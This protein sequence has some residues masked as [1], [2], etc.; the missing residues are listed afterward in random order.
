[1]S[2]LALHKNQLHFT[3]D[4]IK[5]ICPDIE[6]I[7]GAINGFGLLYTV[8]HFNVLEITKT[9]NFVHFSIQEFLA[10]NYIIY[11]LP[12]KELFLLFKEK[13][14]D[15]FYSN[16]F[17]L[18]VAL[19]KGQQRPF[20]DFLCDKNRKICIADKFLTDQ[21]KS[22]H[23]FR[24]FSEAN[25]KSMCST[26]EK[27]FS[28]K[29]IQLGGKVLSPNDVQ[30]VAVLLTHSSIKQW[31][32]LDLFLSHIQH[33]GIRI[34]HHALKDGNVTIREIIL[35]KNSLDSSSDILIK[36]IIISCKVEVL[37]IS[38]NDFVGE[39]KH[40]SSILSDSASMLQV[41]YARFNKL[42]SNAAI[43]I[44]T[45]LRNAKYSQ[46]RLLEISSNNI[47]DDACM[48]IA[49][50]MKINK[51]LKRL[52]MYKTSISIKGVE[53]LLKA[54]Q[55]NTTLATLGLPKY[56]NDDTSKIRLLQR[57]VN[58][59]RKECNCSVELKINFS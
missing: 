50:T 36:D 2:L 59:K 55:S 19:T 28:N 54:L 30:S 14:W 44:F 25:D 1:M 4:E 13:F 11:Y 16:M 20:K 29:Q 39:T 22:L 37:W 18:Y 8:E 24:C 32:K 45:A 17:M 46:L 41:L 23:L 49:I 40:F 6:T 9:F 15:N 10:A 5:E 12:H 26:I 47:T 53:I 38:Y 33:H 43:S 34:L 21:L 51:S 48:V 31:D 52:E 35:T 58:D 42:S 3:L 57:I 7:P 27:A 56:S